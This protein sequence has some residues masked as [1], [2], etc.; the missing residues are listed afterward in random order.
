MN[1]DILKQQYKLVKKQE[2]NYI[3]SISKLSKE[4]TLTEE[5]KIKVYRTLKNYEKKLN[6]ILAQLH[7]GIFKSEDRNIKNPM[8][9]IVEFDVDGNLLSALDD[10][11]DSKLSLLEDL[12]IN[13]NNNRFE[14]PKKNIVYNY[15]YYSV[16]PDRIMGKQKF[17]EKP[18]YIFE[19][20]YGEYDEVVPT[21]AIYDNIFDK[22]DLPQYLL[23]DHMNWFL[24]GSRIIYSKANVP[25]YEIKEIFNDE[26]LKDKN[27]SI[28]DCIQNTEKIIDEL[29]YIREKELNQKRLKINH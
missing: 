11:I 8:Q 1:Y 12:G 13:T 16:Y 24:E 15:K 14:L 6:D 25:S 7:I 3:D 4:K 23:I 28:D 17:T 19:G 9:P 18:I 29:S 20:Y 27:E 10:D 2:L 22:F 5:E 26:L 21:H